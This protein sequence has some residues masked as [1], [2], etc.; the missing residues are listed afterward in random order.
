MA[1]TSLP[2]FMHESDHVWFYEEFTWAQYDHGI[3]HIGGP[4]AGTIYDI[5]PE[6]V[7]VGE[8][9][10]YDAYLNGVPFGYDVYVMAERQCDE[11]CHTWYE[12]VYC[13]KKNY[14]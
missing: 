9:V 13:G 7:F 6:S 10:Y 3:L 2:I 5:P 14:F 8:L 4:R 11:K 12:L 1:F